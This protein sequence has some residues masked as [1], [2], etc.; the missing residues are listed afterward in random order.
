M[1]RRE[2]RS[3]TE[4]GTTDDRDDP[5]LRAVSIVSATRSRGLVSKLA[6]GGPK[7][8]P[9][10]GLRLVRALA[11]VD[12]AALLLLQPCQHAAL[13]GVRVLN[14]SVG[15]ASLVALWQVFGN[16]KTFRCYE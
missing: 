15:L 3:T 2:A 11:L 1:P 6:R 5:H 13:V 12:R 14:H 4:D 16:R 10:V 9:L 7:G 8:G